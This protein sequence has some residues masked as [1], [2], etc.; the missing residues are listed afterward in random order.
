VIL[1]AA[2]ITEFFAEI[3]VAPEVASAQDLPSCPVEFA[4]LEV[5]KHAIPGF[6]AT[7]TQ[8]KFAWA[9]Q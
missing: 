9:L 2:A 4:A 8:A 7:Q 3:N 1:S 5:I 6:A